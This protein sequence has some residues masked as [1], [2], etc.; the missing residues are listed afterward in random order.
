[1]KTF[2]LSLVILL[3]SCA[4]VPT[5]QG[6]KKTNPI[7]QLIQ[8]MTDLNI[9]TPSSEA[10]KQ[11][12]SLDF[13]NQTLGY[14]SEDYEEYFDAT[15]NGN[16]EFLQENEK[17]TKEILALE[18]NETGNSL[19]HLSAQYGQLKIVRYL[20]KL[21]ANPF[22][23]NLK[24]K[25]PLDLAQ[26]K[27]FFAKKNQTDLS[28]NLEKII[29]LLE[30]RTTFKFSKKRRPSDE[31]SYSGN[32]ERNYVAKR[33]IDE[34]TKTRKRRFSCNQKRH[35][36]RDYEKFK[37]YKAYKKFQE[38]LKNLNLEEL[39]VNENNTGFFPGFKTE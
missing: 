27:Y 6:A 5:S 4:I 7:E 17:T 20:L 37:Q 16:L 22:A 1:M 31:R 3:L 24:R 32:D 33:I 8:E 10:M 19:L 25:R 2:F 14:E 29:T 34:Y 11:I 28:Q 38:K 18:E 9:D 21:K 12:S 26:E 30:K 35:G 39:T 23:R 36:D 13:I 15:Q